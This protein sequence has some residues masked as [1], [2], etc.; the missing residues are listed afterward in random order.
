MKHLYSGINNNGKNSSTNK[1]YSKPTGSDRA[2][3]TF[4]PRASV[5]DE[6]LAY[7][8]ALE[9]RSSQCIDKISLIMN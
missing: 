8:K 5:V 2:E 3:K 6:I 7:S 1:Q 4:S 9:I